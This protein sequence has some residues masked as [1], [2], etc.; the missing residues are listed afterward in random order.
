MMP[1]RETVTKTAVDTVARSSRGVMTDGTSIDVVESGRSAGDNEQFIA[2]ADKGIGITLLGHANA[3]EQS[4]GLQVGENNSSYKAV[5]AISVDDLYFV[6][7]WMQ[8]LVDIIWQRNVQDGRIPA[9][10]TDKAEP[11]DKKLHMQ[12]VDMFYD[13]GG[14]VQVAEYKKLG[15]TVSPDQEPLTKPANPLLD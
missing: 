14:E 6:D 8:R 7:Q 9:F 15:L 10:A 11:L 12:I 4:K 3:V 13:H 2:C 5:R 1:M